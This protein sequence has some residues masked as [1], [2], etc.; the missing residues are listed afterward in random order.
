MKVRQQRTPCDLVM[1]MCNF[2]VVTLHC[3]KNVYIALVELV[4]YSSLN[5]ACDLWPMCG[6]WGSITPGRSANKA[7]INH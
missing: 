1:L 2:F 3:P 4:I 5:G 7:L 6:F